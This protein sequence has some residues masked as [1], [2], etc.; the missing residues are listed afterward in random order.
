MW[1]KQREGESKARERQQLHDAGII[2]D[3]SLFPKSKGE[4]LSGYKQMK[5]IVRFVTWTGLCWL[6]C[7]EPSWGGWEANMGWRDLLGGCCSHPRGKQVYKVNTGS[8]R[9]LG[10]SGQVTDWVVLN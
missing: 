5:D 6:L 3:F 7:G 8:G 9:R 10:R 4:P 2:K 1:L